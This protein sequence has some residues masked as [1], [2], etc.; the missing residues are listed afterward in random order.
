MRNWKETCNKRFLLVRSAVRPIQLMISFII[1]GLVIAS[2]TLMAQNKSDGLKTE[3]IKVWGN[4]ESCKQR[5]EKAAK[6]DGVTRA[7]WDI[8]TKMLTLT[9]DPHKTT[10]EKIQKQIAAVGHDTEK[11]KADDKAYANLPGCCKYDRRK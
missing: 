7:V 5:I 11:F 8:K 6:T 2:S 10:S 4:C 3:T 9:Y 1:L